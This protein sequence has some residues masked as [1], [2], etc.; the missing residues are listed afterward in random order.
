MTTS[1]TTVKNGERYYYYKC[2]EKMKHNAKKCLCK[3]IAAEEIEDFVLK[4][5][6]ILIPDRTSL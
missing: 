4:L 5:V 3:D 6:K 1:F 2:G